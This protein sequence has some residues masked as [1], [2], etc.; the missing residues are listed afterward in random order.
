MSFR[1]PP[2]SDPAQADLLGAS[3]HPHSPKSPQ[4]A[5]STIRR[6]P[7]PQ[8]RVTSPQAKK[9]RTEMLET[10]IDIKQRPPTEEETT[11][12]HSVFCQVALPRT[13]VVGDEF[14]RVCGRAQLIVQAGYLADSAGNLVKQAVPYGSLPRLFLMYLVRETLRTSSPEIRMGESAAEFMR[15]LGIQSATGGVNGSMTAFRRQAMAFCAAKLTL[16]IPPTKDHCARTIITSPVHTFDAWK[17]P[18]TGE[19]TWPKRLVLS[20]DFFNEIMDRRAVP[21]DDRAISLLQGSALALDL[22]AWL[23]SRLRRL[24]QPLDISWNILF[25]QFGT[26]YSDTPD[27]LRSF[28][29]KFKIALQ[30]VLAAYATARVDLLRKGLWLHPGPSPVPDP[31]ARQTSPFRA[32]KDSADTEGVPAFG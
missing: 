27:K 29:K 14:R 5:P 26:E 16:S 6:M 31:I 20:A 12:L 4:K 24:T 9:R 28:R 25:A 18:R 3:V 21:L 32:G 10:A 23:A 11:Y 19:T 17:L 22:Y 13:K 15:S 7:F 1:K 30:S 8:T 2:H